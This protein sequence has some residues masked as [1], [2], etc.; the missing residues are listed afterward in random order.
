MKAAMLIKFGPLGIAA[1]AAIAFAA[2]SL[3]TGKVAN[4][5]SQ[6]VGDGAVVAEFGSGLSRPRGV[7]REPPPPKPAATDGAIDLSRP[8][9]IKKD[10]VICPWYGLLDA[11]LSGQQYGGESEGHRRIA[12]L[13]VRPAHD[14]WRTFD[15]RQ[16]T[17][18]D[19]SISPDKLVDVRCDN[20]LAQKCLARPIDI[21]N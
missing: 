5:P 1:V 11:Y 10:R 19:D 4:H 3:M 13:F 14:C 17:V 12:E 16:V 15:R 8:V 9:F 2:L 18:L 7:V 21:E 6:S 20:A